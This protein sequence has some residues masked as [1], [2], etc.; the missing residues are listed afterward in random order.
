MIDGIAEHPAPSELEIARDEI[1]S[2]AREAHTRF[3]DHFKSR[4][5]ARREFG[6]NTPM[7]IS[8]SDNEP[9]VPSY[10]NWSHIEG[11]IDCWES[12]VSEYKNGNDLF[13]LDIQIERYKQSLGTKY[14]ENT[15]AWNE[16]FESDEWITAA[17]IIFAGHDLGN[18][19]EK[20]DFDANGD[21]VFADTYLEEGA[22]D[23]SADLVETLIREKLGS[24][25]RSDQIITFARHIIDQTKFDFSKDP[26]KMDEVPF[27]HAVQAIDQIASAYFSTQS[28]AITVA[29]LLNEKYARGE[30]DGMSV[31]NFLHF[32]DA[33]LYKLFKHRPEVFER[34]RIY[35]RGI[36]LDKHEE[37]LGISKLIKGRFKPLDFEQHIREL[38]A[39][40]DEAMNRK[41]ERYLSDGEVDL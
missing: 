16:F 13:D 14:T 26:A 9:I 38:I 15:E 18:L 3:D 29:G 11:V 24:H 23:R 2:F 37:I 17:K 40:Y 20:G 12:V 27:W 1:T 5:T 36:N 41:A 7:K 19:T 4:G 30:S 28:Y 34:L 21:I 35:L 33:R 31:S 6:V 10:H 32:R 8:R 25:P 39:E 22:E